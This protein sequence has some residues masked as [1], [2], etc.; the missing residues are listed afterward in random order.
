MSRRNR[1][2]TATFADEAAAI[3]KNLP[4][5]A[6]TLIADATND[7]TIPFFSGA[8][9]H[10]DDTLIQRGGGKGL[11]IYD[12][13]ER[14]PHAGAM[15]Q[16]RRSRLT[17]REWTVTAAS[18]SALDQT[19]VEVVRDI[20]A[21]IPFDRIC[22]DLLDA[23]LKGFAISEIVWA[24]DGAQIRPAQVKSH[25][26]RRF[27]FGQDW[28]PRLLTWTN[29][30]DGIEL[31]ERKFIVH[32]HGVKGNNPYGLGVG[33][34]LFW[35]VLFKREG[36]AFWLHFLDKF[37]GPTVVGKTPYGTISE[38]QRRLLNTLSS[39]RTSSAV[40]VPIGT[41][42][43]FLE[44]SRGGSVSYQDFLSYWDKQISICVT[45]ETLTTDIGS[46]GSK[47][48]S[49]THADMLDMLV[50]SDADLLTDSLGDTLIQWI[51]DYNVPGAGVP[52]VSRE[53]QESAAARAAARKAMAEAEAAEVDTLV[54]ILTLAARIEDDGQARE[55]ISAFE[56]ATR[57]SDGAIDQLVIARAAFASAAPGRG[58]RSP[59][60]PVAFADGL[61]KKHFGPG[62]PCC[63]A[64]E[65]G[66]VELITDQ[67]LEQTKRLFGRRIEAIRRAVTTDHLDQARINLVNLAASWT[68][69]ALARQLVD[70]M[71]LAAY[72]GREAAFQDGEVASSF[73]AS[74]VSLTFGEQRDFLRQK[75]PTPTDWWLDVM[76]GNHDR[77]FVIAGA[78]DVA[79]LEE[80][81]D[82]LTGY[83]ENGG[84]VNDFAAD[85]DRIVQKYGWDYRGERDW[86]IRTIFETNMRT[87]FM[88][89]RLKQMRDPDVVKLRP[90]WQ[91]V[92]ADSRIPM[93]PRKLHTDWDGIVLRWDDPW[94]DT[95]FPPN[96][97]LCSCGVRSLTR[98]DLRRLG[99]D[100]PDEAPRDA[101]LPV[102]D[103]AS[104]QLIMQPAGIGY[105]WD[106]M[107]GDLWER[108]LVPSAL[109]NEA[110][111]I[112]TS[113][114]QLVLI[115]K[116]DPIADMIARARETTA[117]LM[118]PNLAP[119]EYVNGFLMPFGAD[120]DRA[121]R[122][123]DAAGM[124]MVI[125]ADLLRARD[126]T[127]KADKRGRGIYAQMLAEAILDPDE[128]WLG[129]AQKPNSAK[130]GVTDI[131]LDRRYIR[132][133][134]NGGLFAVFELTR[135]WWEGVTTYPTTDAK[136][137][138]SFT[139]LDAR[140]GGK[141]I[142]KRK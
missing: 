39:I 110:G 48:A 33:S 101:L 119:E 40:T 8:L 64:A 84:T 63:F 70:A 109:I 5:E 92:H 52:K 130:P 7:I 115:D 76:R 53:R 72:S 37:A 17:A 19:A 86:R 120:I 59:A 106:Y 98:S 47:A 61:K 140:R 54:S 91:Y 32:R 138:P 113:I 36:I 68:P 100:G 116:P 13:V 82:A 132:V 103:P 105:G 108:G 34:R 104:K 128:I 1:R 79:M 6:R 10:A 62:E 133:F 122:F 127:F 96:D 41:D 18:D 44:A 14:D 78:T 111:G 83:V 23:T 28:R 121:V 26:Q 60:D 43:Q 95:H 3:R 46:A 135:N 117:K 65:N 16:K 25:D 66:P 107:P 45:G 142:W 29:M 88:A 102:I 56:T 80:F 141:L 97:W 15:L 67:L 21:K 50:D 51:V 87:S 124:Q 49:E 57:M 75:R 123:I 77:A 89:G 22:S 137:R 9:Q 81:Q 90:Y 69:D 99:K 94:W 55:F 136:G 139:G 4:V 73:A 134:P 35:P 74:A 126:G 11:K 58:A 112:E 131:V 93:V 24:R 129:L 2:Q 20:L 114:R 85:F 12:E 31:P 38:E 71:E 118:E 125:S 27:V 42:V 30:R